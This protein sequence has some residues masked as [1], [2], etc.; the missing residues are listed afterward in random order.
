MKIPSS[1][2]VAFSALLTFPALL[3]YVLVMFLVKWRLKAAWTKRQTSTRLPCLL[4]SVMKPKLKKI[5]DFPWIPRNKNAMFAMSLIFTKSR[6]EENWLGLLTLRCDEIGSYCP[7][8][9]MVKYRQSHGF[10]CNT[11]DKG[12]IGIWLALVSPLKKLQ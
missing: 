6:S 11:W 5:P 2:S 12:S 3:I 10:P 1:R 9:I 7:S 8:I 4:T